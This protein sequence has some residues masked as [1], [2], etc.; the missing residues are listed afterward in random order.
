M[1]LIIK[2]VDEGQVPSH[3]YQ[4]VDTEEWDHSFKGW[5][6]AQSSSEVLT[7]LPTASKDASYYAAITSVKKQYTLTFDSN[8]GSPIQ[9]ITVD[10]GTQI[11]QPS[12]PTKEGFTF[13]FVD[14]RCFIVK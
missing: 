6:T 4:P 2:S 8:G 9:A 11:E 7:A 14:K 5:K 12:F 10:H 1:L 3:N 13:C